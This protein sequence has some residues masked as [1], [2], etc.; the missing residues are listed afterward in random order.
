[1]T[2]TDNNWPLPQWYTV[3]TLWGHSEVCDLWF[4]SSVS[5]REWL[6]TGGPPW[7]SPQDL[8]SPLPPATTRLVWPS[9]FSLYAASWTW[10]RTP[11]AA[12]AGG[13]APSVS[14]CVQ[15]HTPRDWR[16]FFVRPHYAK[17]F[18]FVLRCRRY[19]TVV[20]LSQNEA[21][22]PDR[23]FWWSS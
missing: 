23:A 5:P 11:A 6:D 18:D 9:P 2:V 12:T 14:P 21:C 10:R 1:M 13:P 7:T 22:C 16:G 8:V 3:L 4:G 20:C 19:L 15:R 17:E